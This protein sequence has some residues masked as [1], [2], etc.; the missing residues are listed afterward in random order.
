MEHPVVVSAV[1]GCIEMLQHIV[2]WIIVIASQFI[3]VFFCM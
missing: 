3:I 2:K 1:F